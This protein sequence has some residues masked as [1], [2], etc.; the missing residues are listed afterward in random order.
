M[1]VTTPTQETDC[2]PNARASHGEPVHK[3]WSL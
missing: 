1:A 3:I 2:S